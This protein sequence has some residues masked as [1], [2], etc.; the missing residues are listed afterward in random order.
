MMSLD[1][2]SGER[3]ISRRIF[4]KWTGL[5]GL[6]FFFFMSLGERGEKKDPKGEKSLEEG[7]KIWLRGSPY[8]GCSTSL[9]FPN[10]LDHLEK[11]LVDLAYFRT[12]LM[13]GEDFG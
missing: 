6:G 2:F 9:S 13:F 5:S 3:R 8:H 1:L 10:H 12:S 11:G 4:L 7:R